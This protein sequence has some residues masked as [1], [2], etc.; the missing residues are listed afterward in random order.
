MACP[1]AVCIN[2]D[3][4]AGEAAIAV[5]PPD[6]EAAGGINVYFRIFINQLG[7]QYN[8]HDVPAYIFLYLFPGN[9][10]AVLGRYNHGIE[11]FRTVVC[12]IFHSDLR[13]SIWTKVG[14][15]SVFADEGE[16]L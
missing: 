11:S 14:Q 4:P 3:L 15:R 12:I 7:G 13:F 16:L 6:H 8:I 9:I 1:A 10:V 5:G 2:N